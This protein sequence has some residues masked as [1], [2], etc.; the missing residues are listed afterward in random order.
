[1]KKFTIEVTQQH[2]DRANSVREQFQKKVHEALAD[3]TTLPQL[4]RS[5]PPKID[6]LPGIPALEGEA[7]LIALTEL[8]YERLDMSD[9]ILI[10]G[11][12]PNDTITYSN[13]D[14]LANWVFNSYHYPDR[15]KP[16]TIEAR[17]GKG[18]GH[19]SAKIV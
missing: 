4:E 6:R 3:G 10:I 18:C 9:R 12:K 16:I 11:N 17:S 13:S 7:V 15:C 2:I 1:M 19:P 8:G 14:E 5:N